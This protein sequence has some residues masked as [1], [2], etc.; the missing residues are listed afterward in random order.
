MFLIPL[1]FHLLFVLTH[2]SFP[3]YLLPPPSTSISLP[4][5][6]TLKNLQLS[7]PFKA[8]SC[9]NS[10][11]VARL[12]FVC[13]RACVFGPAYLKLSPN[14]FYICGVALLVHTSVF[15]CE[16]LCVCVCV[17]LST[18]PRT[19]LYCVLDNPH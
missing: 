5:S 9:R 15:K 4:P 1:F 13:M 2:T 6:F 17:G 12:W 7:L 16:C 11:L 8:S 19:G 14:Y 18:S 10:W 3:T